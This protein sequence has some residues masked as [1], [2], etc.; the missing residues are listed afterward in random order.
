MACMTLFA[1]PMAMTTTPLA[2][3]VQYQDAPAWQLEANVESK[4]LRMSWVVVTD[5][6]GSRR[7]QIQWARPA[8]R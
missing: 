8:D 3:V 4:P 1:P 2:R 6:N 7:L 5:K